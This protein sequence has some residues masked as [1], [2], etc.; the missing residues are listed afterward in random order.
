MGKKRKAGSGS[1][2]AGYQV[3]TGASSAI[4]DDHFFPEGANGGG[5]GSNALVIDPAVVEAERE[6]RK[7]AVP[8]PQAI[9]LSKKKRKKLQ[10]IL[11]RKRKKI[12][13]ERLIN[14]MQGKFVTPEQQA[15]L[16]KTSEIGKG[17]STRREQ[18]QRIHQL[19]T[20]GIDPEMEDLRAVYSKGSQV[21]ASQLKKEPKKPQAR[22]SQHR[23]M[24]FDGF[25]SD[26]DDSDHD[27]SDEGDEASENKETSEESNRESKTSDKVLGDVGHG[28]EDLAPVP[29][30][31][32]KPAEFIPRGPDPEDIVPAPV[33]T[34][35]DKQQAIFVIPD[36]TQA[37][38]DARSNLPIIGEEHVIMEKIRAN[39]VVII[40]GETGSGKSTQVPQFLYEGGYS[41]PGCDSATG[42][43]GMTEPRRVAAIAMA[44]RIGYEMNLGAPR[45][46]Y[47]IRH[48]GNASERTQIKIM[49]DGILMREVSDDFMLS[50][51][52]ALILDEAHER[53]MH[54][55]ILIGLLSRIVPLRR[56]KWEEWKKNK[57]QQSKDTDC[58]EDSESPPVPGPLKLVI[59]S[60][61]L[62]VE[63]FVANR[64]L[65]PEPPPVV[66]IKA[67]QHPVTVRFSKRTPEFYMEEAFRICK[68]IHRKLPDGAILV[69]VT[70]QSEVKGLVRKLREGLGEREIR[71][72]AKKKL[73]RKRTGALSK[74]SDQSKVFVDLDS[75]R[76]DENDNA[77]ALE[78]GEEPELGSDDEEVKFR[79]TD[80]ADDDD[81]DYDWDND[82]ET[83]GDEDDEALN[84]VLDAESKMSRKE[85]KIDVLPFFSLLSSDDQRKV[86]APSPEGYRRI[87]VSTNVAETSLTIPNIRYVIDC[88]KAKERVYRGNT[89]MSEFVVDWISR[90]SAQQRA[91][92]A[93]RTGPGRCYRMYSTALY[94]NVMNDFAEPEI[95]QMP[96]DG[97]VLQMK[98]MNIHNIVN[99]PFPSAPSHASLENSLTTLKSLGA[100]NVDDEI[101][102]LGQIIGRF[103]ISPRYGKMI[104]VGLQRYEII[105][106]IIA[107]CAAMS[108]RELFHTFNHSS[109]EGDRREGEGAEDDKKLSAQVE[110]KVNKAVHFFAGRSPRSDLITLLRAIGAFEYSQ[111][112]E[113][114]CRSH[115][116][117]HKGMLEVR[118]LRAQLTRTVAALQ[119]SMKGRTTKDGKTIDLTLNPKLKPPTDAQEDIIRQVMLSAFGDCV[120]R[121]SSSQSNARYTLYEACN[122]SFDEL[123][124]LHPDSALVSTREPYLIY[125]ELQQTPKGMYLRKVTIIEPQWL[126]VLVRTGT[127]LGKALDTPVPTWNETK[128]CVDGLVPSSFGPKRWDVPPV[129]MK[130]PDDDDATVR[131]FA[132]FL[133][134]GTVLPRL[135]AFREHLIS[136]PNVVTKGFPQ[137][138]I[139]ALL[140]PLRDEGITTRSQLVE[141]MSARPRFL[142]DAFL[143]WL[144]KTLHAE[145]VRSWPPLE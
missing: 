34:D 128:G 134:E 58:K 40:C 73:E 49:T 17:K 140:Q 53:S 78:A 115:G 6:K 20:A 88:G 62:R 98:G 106:Y 118:K 101:T 130:L 105:E 137:P 19:R 127:H 44:A 84:E 43:I 33:I 89:G 52:S 86:F 136:Q 71:T 66:N 48:E 113:A 138:K 117:R 133:L 97:L 121:K 68:K 36:R 93:G 2:D 5:N 92:R 23:Q 124:V 25:D 90:A 28:A 70:G 16:L 54:T 91:G 45:V 7:A 69:F 102:P 51:Y 27:S 18:A 104:S 39:D 1:A 10:K 144:P 110:R 81:D 42:M 122:P 21:I 116:L 135:A 95:T 57:Q 107:I 143:Q 41:H 141:V 120:A 15:L 55:D 126:P 142:L 72:N 96:I 8:E 139:M 131:W 31:S 61:T 83:M 112:N 103:P 145:C 119:L 108:V 50:K 64:K 3:R 47:Q 111:G 75:Y 30:Q 87:V 100:L 85:S 22:G 38:Q 13:R 79:D 94:A 80:D 11:D 123:L 65:F 99:F 32:K 125:H 77:H 56:K 109:S 132:R 26:S 35:D 60:A 9:P 76:V 46:A 59:M 114:W 24:E 82:F 4:L 67:R 74:E 129:K 63:D 12:D 29:V 14:E 37:V